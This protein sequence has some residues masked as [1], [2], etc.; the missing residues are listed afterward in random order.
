M[1]TAT[2]PRIKGIRSSRGIYPHTPVSVPSR[3]ESHPVRLGDTLHVRLRFADGSEMSVSCRNA[4]T[5][6]E[7]VGG[8]RQ[9][10]RGRRGLVKMCVRNVSRGW[11]LEKPLMLY[12]DTWH[13][14]YRQ[15][16]CS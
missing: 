8:V 16:L 2:Y 11:T 10:A 6:T 14:I 1:N 9:A 12:G 13:G 5:M 7:L 15:N 4:A 3:H